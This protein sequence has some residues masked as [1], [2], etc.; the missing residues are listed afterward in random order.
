MSYYSWCKLL[1]LSETSVFLST[2]LNVINEWYFAEGMEY[3]KHFIKPSK[4]NEYSMDI[5]ERAVLFYSLFLT[6]SDTGIYL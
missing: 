2:Q 6:R 3:D 1:N 5:M 4:N